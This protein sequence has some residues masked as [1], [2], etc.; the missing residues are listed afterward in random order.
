MPAE[1]HVRSVARWFEYRAD[2]REPDA[3]VIS[4]CSQC[5]PCPDTGRHGK[6]VFTG[7]R[8][9]TDAPAVK[10]VGRATCRRAATLR[11]RRESYDLEDGFYVDTIVPAGADTATSV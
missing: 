11:E 2:Q 1:G 4:P 5:R 10:V 7:I 3:G 6:H 9:L 8:Q